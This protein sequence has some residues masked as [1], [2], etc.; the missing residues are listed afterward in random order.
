MAP[1]AHAFADEFPEAE[2]WHLLDDRLVSGRRRA[3]AGSPRRCSG[4][5]S[6]LI[7]YAVDGGADAVQLSCSM[8]GPGRRRRGRG[9][10]RDGAGLGPGHVRRTSRAD[11]PS[12][13]ASSARW[14]P[15]PPTA[16]QRLG[17]AWLQEAGVDTE[18]EHRSSPA[19][20]R[21]PAPATWSPSTQLLVDAADD[22]AQQVDLIVLAQ[23]SLAPALRRVGR[24][25]WP[26]R[27]SARRTW[28]PSTLARA[29]GREP[30]DDRARAA[31]PTTSPA[32]P[33]SRRP[34][35]APACRSRCCS[36]SPTRDAAS[37]TPTPWSSR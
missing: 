27:C 19:R 8:Y 25:T 1:A 18:I 4:R 24:A 34:C 36:A 22:L 37:R 9:P 6:T 16:P 31:S 12:G 20:P 13:S 21:P 3:R 17:A 2:L 15:R 30:I 23:Y 7:Q 29:T 32:A 35:A 11:H 10:A 5:M 26:S 14:T 28:P 33:T